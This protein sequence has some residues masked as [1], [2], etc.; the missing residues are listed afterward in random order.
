MLYIVA[1]YHFMQFEEKINEPNLRK[2]W[3][4]WRKFGPQ[5]FFHGFYHYYILDFASYHCVKLQGK[6]MSQTWEN[7]KTPSLW[8]DF[9]PFDSNSERQLF[10]S[11]T[12]L[13]QRLDIMVSY[14]HVQYQKKLMI[15]SWE[16]L[17]TDQ[18]TDHRTRR[19][20]QRTYRRLDRSDFKGCSPTNVECPAGQTTSSSYLTSLNDIAGNCSN[21]DNGKLIINGYAFRTFGEKIAFSWLTC[22]VKSVIVI[23]VKMVLQF[24]WNSIYKS[25]M[26][27]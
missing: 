4:L 10:F 23:S 5:Y 24:Y 15:R 9:G 18:R 8:P 1:S 12:W 14:H 11:K 20:D 2:F 26:F 13:R 22:I 17:V 21:L 27:I 19:T 25:A 6:L 3:P 7:G 16:N